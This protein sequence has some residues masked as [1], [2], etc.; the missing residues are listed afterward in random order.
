MFRL[1][2]V[3][4]WDASPSSPAGA[5]CAYT[6]A[7]VA[8]TQRQPGGKKNGCFYFI[9]WKTR[10][11]VKMVPLQVENFYTTFPYICSKLKSF[12]LMTLKGE[13]KALLA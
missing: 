12:S 2:E 3:G 1:A 9:M 13:I 5:L 10:Q 4:N 11:K 8:P 6:L 7:S